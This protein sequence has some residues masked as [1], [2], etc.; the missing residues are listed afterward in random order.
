MAASERSL[1]AL[2]NPVR[3]QIIDMLHS[4]PRS[5][6]EI[7]RDLPISRPAISKHLR[8][9]QGANLVSYEQ[10]GTKNIY[11]IDL[12]GFDELRTWLNGFWDDA[13]QR[14]RMVCESTVPST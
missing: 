4:R 14:F 11:Q 2:G 5:V 7:A 10:V 6:T 13:L 12:D 8:I 9:L 3:R 1:D